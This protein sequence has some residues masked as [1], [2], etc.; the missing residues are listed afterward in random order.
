[1]ENNKVPFPQADDFEKIISIINV[2]D[3]G[4]IKNKEA[5]S[6]YLDGITPRQ[7]QYY[8]SAAMYLGIINKEKE[9]SEEGNYLRSLNNARQII[10]CIRLIVSKPIFGTVYFSEKYLHIKY[11]RCDIEELMKKETNINNIEVIHRRAQTVFKWIDWINN[12]I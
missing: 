12:K 8:I 2:D 7:V 1:M 3:K 5:L 10:E 11:N 9:F 6:A 4:K